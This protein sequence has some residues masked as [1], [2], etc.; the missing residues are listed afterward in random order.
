MPHPKDLHFSVIRNGSLIGQ[1]CV[2]FRAEALML[3]VDISLEISVRLGPIPVFR[4]THKVTETWVDGSFLAFE[5]ETI[6]N[7][8][9]YRISAA[10]TQKHVIV[11][12]STE[13]RKVFDA[14]TIPLTH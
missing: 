11:E 1:H 4:Y 14:Q 5:S 7:A 12:S 6:E 9:R 3:I 2:R 13:G 8:K 10:K